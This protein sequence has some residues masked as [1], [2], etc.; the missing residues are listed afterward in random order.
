MLMDR[1]HHEVTTKAPAR[2][3]LE[4][5]IVHSEDGCATADSIQISDYQGLD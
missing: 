3:D 4:S 1:S 2:A 5:F